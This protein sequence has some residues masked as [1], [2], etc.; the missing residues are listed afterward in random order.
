M[1]KNKLKEWFK[2]YAIAELISLVF[3]LVFSN[4]S[5]LIFNNV[6]ISAFVATWASNIGFYGTIIY[7][8]LKTM[9]KKEKKLR[10]MSF[11]KLAR[12]MLIEFGPAEYLDSFVIRPFYLA[13]FPYLIDNYSLAITIGT[14]LANITYY[15]PTIFSYEFRKKIFKD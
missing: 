3:A 4:L 12:N 15:I 14:I 5:M 11:L 13:L 7:K 2:R 1:F 8:D 10:G 9:K 6:I